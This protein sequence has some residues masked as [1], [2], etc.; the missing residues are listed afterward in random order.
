MT[1]T[2]TIR[3]SRRSVLAGAGAFVLGFHVAPKGALGQAAAPAATPEINAWVVIHPDDRVVLRMARSEMG[4]G[5][6]TGLCQMIA[7][8][9]HCDWAK[10]ETE[11][12]TPGQSLARN[13]AWGNFLTAGS[14]GIRQSQDYVRRGGAAARIMLVQAAAAQWNVPASECAARDS[15]ITHTPTGRTL[16]YGQ[17]AAAAA[18]LTPPDPVPLKDPREW[19][20]IGRS[21]PRLDT[22]AK[23]TG[24]LVYGS[25][26]KMPGM[27][28][29]VPKR[30]PVFGG[31]VRSFDAARVRSMPGVKHVLQVGDSA[32][33]VVADTF[34]QAKV[35]LDALPIEWDVG[36]NGR[37][38]QST[39]DAMLDEGLNAAEAFVGN[40]NGDARAAIAAAPRKVEAVYS[41]PF[42]NHA[43][44]EPMNATVVWTAARCDVWCPT[45]NGEAALVATAQA[46]GLPQQQCDVHRVD[47]GGGFGRRTTHDWLIDAVLTAKQIPGVPIK[48]MWTRE[49]DM[50]HGRY[51]PVTKAKM[52]A[53]IDAQ[54][55]ITGLHMRIS[56]Q[57]ILSFV[58]PTALQNGRDP[59]QFQGLNAGG[60]ESAIGYSFPNL[61]IDHAMRNTHVPPH[62]WRGVNHNQNAIYLECFLDEVAHATNQDPL[63]LRRKLM[64]NH[65]KHL[66]VLNAV[67]ERVGWGSAPPA[68][69]FRGIAQ[70]MG[71]GSYVAAAAEVSVSDAGVLRIHRI[72]AATDSGVAVNPRQ[73]E[74]Q[75]EGSFVYGLSALLYGECTVKD[76]AIEQTNFDTYNVLR[77]DEM[78]QVETIVMPSGGFWGGVGEPTIMVAAPAVLNAIFAATGKRIR[79]VPLKDQDLRRA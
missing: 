15:V 49:E 56:G 69:R 2:E 60:A 42:Q 70:Q 27:L 36:D 5:T 4:Q 48:T 17:V 23:T 41:Y 59:V 67:A 73:I 77:M 38:Q 31:R 32:V 43:P 28:V 10:I 30:C 76:G 33:A 74:M 9:L 11:Y 25:D 50:T 26:L 39:I 58:F 37:V 20:L 52:T 62:F 44:M 66:A 65:P 29:S 72:V 79:S 51:H 8:E 46:A 13:R 78:P 54:G 16:R 19:T 57:S 24:A 35:A 3:A 7:E 34:W 18:R 22:V 71:F 63:A 68:G 64:G 6:R 40:S 45:Q 47:L 12:V 14:Q 53:G 21:V 75:V 1:T 55:N 61:L